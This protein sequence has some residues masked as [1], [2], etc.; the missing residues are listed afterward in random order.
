[1]RLVDVSSLLS[2]KPPW[3]FSV[4]CTEPDLTDLIWSLQ[5]AELSRGVVRR[6]RG[7][8]M[9]TTRSLFNEIAASL[10]FPDYFGEN[11]NALDE[12]LTDLEWLP[13]DAYLLVISNALSVLV[14]EEPQQLGAFVSVL[15]RACEEWSG[16]TREGQPWDRGPTPFHI[17]LHCQQGQE[18]NLV[19]RFQ[20]AGAQPITQM[21]I[22][23]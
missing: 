7:T 15:T 6:V 22:V 1:M 8:K 9:T 21:T 10:Q 19:R 20:S 17:A 5:Q 16:G 3:V 23:R 4:A 14:D 13:G 2:T 11:W 18:A 12:C